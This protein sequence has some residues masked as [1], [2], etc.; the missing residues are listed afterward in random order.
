MAHVTVL[1]LYKPLSMLNDLATPPGRGSQALVTSLDNVM[2]F[3]SPIVSCRIQS[4]F[5]TTTPPPKHPQQ[6]PT[7]PTPPP[8]PPQNTPPTKPTPQTPP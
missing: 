4:L 1:S 6:T 3:S 5:N 7:T 2:S 8:T